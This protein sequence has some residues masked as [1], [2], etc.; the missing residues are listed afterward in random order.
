MPVHQPRW[1]AFSAIHECDITLFWPNVG[2]FRRQS[3]A[4]PTSIEDGGSQSASD[5]CRTCWQM[6][7][8]SVTESPMD[9]LFHPVLAHQLRTLPIFP[10][11]TARL[12]LNTKNDWHYFGKSLLSPSM[13]RTVSE[14]EPISESEQSDTIPED[15]ELRL[16]S[17]LLSRTNSI[18]HPHSDRTSALTASS[19][20]RTKQSLPPS[21]GCI[22][23]HPGIAILAKRTICTCLALACSKFGLYTVVAATYVT[24]QTAPFSTWASSNS[25]GK[26][27]VSDAYT[28]QEQL[29]STKKPT[30]RHRMVQTSTSWNYH[31]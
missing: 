13:A 19:G 8:S 6:C 21:T 2:A 29:L 23:C 20:W 17:N 11:T 16:W 30:A 27:Y 5:E 1:A 9:T 31:S 15:L 18:P 3:S 28:C 12:P 10:I 22:N 25:K 26:G 7:V 4:T 24:I 14:D